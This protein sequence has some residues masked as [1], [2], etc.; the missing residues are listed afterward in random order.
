MWFPEMMK[1]AP[2]LD[3]ARR[4][5]P[6]KE[7]TVLLINPFYRKDPRASFGKHVL[8]PTLALTSIAAA[9]PRHWQVRIWDENLLQGH[10]P[11]EP[12]PEVVG[13]SVHLTFA[14]R[15]YELA[16]WYRRRGAIVV[17]GGLHAMSCPD[18]V[19][20][21]ADVIAIGD[22][23]ALWPRILQDVDAGCLKKRYHADFSRDYKLDPNPRRELL[24]AESYLTTLSLIAT[25][26]CHNRCGF[27]YMSTRGVNMPY[28]MRAPE[29]VAAEFEASDE[30]YGVF[31]DNNLG[32]DRTYLRRLCRELRKVDKIWSA[33]V[34][35]DVT[36]EPSLVKEMALA[37]CTGVFVGFESLVEQNLVDAGKKTPQPEEYTRR[38]D[39]FHTFGIQVNA[40]FVFGF[41]HDTV[42]V[43][44]KTVRWIEENRLAC[45]TFHIL[46]PYPGTPLFR[47]LDK[48]KRILHRN[49][50]LYD[51]SHVVFEPRRMRAEE[52]QAGYQWCYRQMFS[53][54]SILRRC[55]RSVEDVP[56]YLAMSFLYK[57]S[58]F[59]WAQLIRHRL[60]HRLWRPLVERSRRRHLKLRRKL[61]ARSFV[62]NRTAP[63]SPGV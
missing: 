39:I 34:S 43:F 56:A 11:H 42:D 29:Q 6:P 12:F 44:E 36:D 49:W 25:R 31:V 47:R 28:Q 7:R 46:T 63:V 17:M 16:D 14:R 27:C 52:L 45:A 48:Q 26:G 51:T 10:P 20:R 37:G 41:D 58:N 5:G 32:S 8:T 59:L 18:E 53:L 9:T 62:S 1:T 40:S 55:P 24:P 54:G 4:T 23:V 38:V 60:T 30:P 35:I 57:R 22:G 61:E 50:D 21:H 13:I 33:A 15:A 3:K 19:A 2:Q